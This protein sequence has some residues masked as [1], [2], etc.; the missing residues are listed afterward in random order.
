[1][2]V[3]IQWDKG[4]EF[5]IKKTWAFGLEIYSASRA[6]K[7]KKSEST[8]NILWS[9]NSEHQQK[10]ILKL[11]KRNYPKD[12]KITKEKLSTGLNCDKTIS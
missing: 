4:W 3:N 10:K 11:L 5:S 6:A 12:F 1:M 9:K 2:R 7:R 8:I